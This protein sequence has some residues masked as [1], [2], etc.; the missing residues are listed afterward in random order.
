MLSK[1][2]NLI[3]KDVLSVDQKRANHILSEQKRRNLIRGGFKEL[4]ELIPTLKNI[5]NSKSTILFK[6]V[7]YIKQLEK[8][9][10]SLKDKLLLLEQKVK[11]KQHKS[12][13]KSFSQKNKQLELLQEQLKL[14]Q[15][16]LTKH[17]IQFD[18]ISIPCMDD[19]PLHSPTLTHQS[20]VYNHQQHQ[21]N[22]SANSNNALVI[23]SDI[24]SYVPSFTIPADETYH[25]QQHATNNLLSSGKLNHLM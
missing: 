7:D 22:H 6:S 3:K 9:N 5:N 16:L 23:P 14:Q 11:Q 2:N 25:Y 20:I 10:K 19:T 21:Q 8:R 1:N 24:I 13:L 17:N 4:T 15:E 12:K 18:S